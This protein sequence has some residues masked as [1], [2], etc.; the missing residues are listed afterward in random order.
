MRLNPKDPMI[1]VPFHGTAMAHFA[2]GRYAEA[3]DW[4]QRSLRRRPDGSIAPLIFAASLSQL[5]RLE[6]ARAALGTAYEGRRT[7]A[8]SAVRRNVEFAAPAVAERFLDGLRRAG[9]PE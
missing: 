7:P 6:E 5:D 1:W 3:A 8:L 2:A 4:A 9:L